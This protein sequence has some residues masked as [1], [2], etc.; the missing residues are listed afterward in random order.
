MVTNDCQ[1]IRLMLHVETGTGAA[2]ELDPIRAISLAGN[3][4]DAAL[5]KLA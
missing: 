3:L 4:I 5:P 1:T 2:V